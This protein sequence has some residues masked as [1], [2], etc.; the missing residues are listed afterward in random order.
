MSVKAMVGEEIRVAPSS[1]GTAR[2]MRKR[3]LLR[4]HQAANLRHDERSACSSFRFFRSSH[5]LFEVQ[6]LLQWGKPCLEPHAA[7]VGLRY[8]WRRTGP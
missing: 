4:E 7:E 6:V 3:P 2:R 8:V 1:V 5:I